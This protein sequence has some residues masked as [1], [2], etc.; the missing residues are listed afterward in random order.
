M[1]VVG[2]IAMR[3]A[4]NQQPNARSTI[5]GST[6]LLVNLGDKLGVHCSKARATCAPKIRAERERHTVRRITARRARKE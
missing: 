6:T 3:R 5:M 1:V 2:K 4:A